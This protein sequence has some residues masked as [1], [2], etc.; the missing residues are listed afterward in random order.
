MPVSF[1]SPSPRE[2]DGQ[3][4]GDPSP[5]ELARD[6][7]L[8]DADDAQIVEKRGDAGPLSSR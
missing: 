5:H 4:V 2:R 7:H 1:L 6:F 8:D 3:S